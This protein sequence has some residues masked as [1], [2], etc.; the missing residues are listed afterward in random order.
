VGWNIR[1]F[2]YGV[3]EEKIEIR[4]TSGTRSRDSFFM[5]IARP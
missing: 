4:T 5:D 2:R 1:I 3:Q